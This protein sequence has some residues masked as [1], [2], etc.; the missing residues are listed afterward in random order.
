MRCSMEVLA[1]L[2]AAG[3]FAALVW[4]EESKT[5]PKKDILAPTLEELGQWLKK[6]G[7]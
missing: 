5:P 3:M 2:F 6:Q 7:D 4:P 1:I